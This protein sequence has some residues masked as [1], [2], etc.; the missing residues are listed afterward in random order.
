MA[1]LGVILVSKAHNAKDK[2]AK[3]LSTVATVTSCG[4]TKELLKQSPINLDQLSTIIPLGNFAPPGHVIPTEHMY[5]NYLNAP[6]PDGTPTPVK[7]TL[8]V[9]A[10]MTVNR[11]TLFDNQSATKPFDSYRLDFTVCK[12]VKGYFIHVLQLNDKLTAAMSKP[13]DQTQTS[14]AGGGK[15]EHTYGKVVNVKL[16]AGEV[17]GSGGGG[18]GLPGGL[19]IGLYDSRSATPTFANP[20]RWGQDNKIVCSL[21]YFSPAVSKALYSHIGDYTFKSIEPGDPKCGQVYQDKLGTAQGV[22][23]GPDSPKGQ[24]GEISHQLTLGH[25]NFNH[26]KGTFALGDAVRQIGIDPSSVYAFDPTTS[27]QKNLDF[28]LVKPGATVYC[29]QT[30]NNNGQPTP[31]P[32]LIVQL[33]TSNS[34]KLGT[35]GASSCGAGPWAFTKSVDY[36]R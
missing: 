21:D 7:T 25:S 29:Y 10:D 9:P 22:W 12:Q 17:L 13:Y 18:A 6:L 2:P 32:V 33:A 20:S 24:I 31:G 4:T 5:Y 35:T 8:Y 28:G 11:I 26:A 19:D 15:L 23:F 14:D 16:T 34:L 36:V 27:G 1:G 3:S 30:V